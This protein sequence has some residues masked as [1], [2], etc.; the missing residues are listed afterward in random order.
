MLS[1][2]SINMNT[3]CTVKDNYA[4]SSSWRGINR[5]ICKGVAKGK[6]GGSWD[7]RDPPFVSLFVSKQPTIF[8]WQ[9]GEYPL[10]D[11]VWAPLLLI[12]HWFHGSP[13]LLWSVCRHWLEQEWTDF[14]PCRW[15]WKRFKPSLRACTFGCSLKPPRHGFRIL[16]IKFSKFVVCNSCK[17][18]RF[19]S[20]SFMVYY[21]LFGVFLS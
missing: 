14:S 8:R 11:P 6:G 19:S 16:K 3:V 7:A 5:A 10:Y 21:N 12:N 13:H 17:S 18:S 1:L 20:C 15:D 4:W 2:F 9:S